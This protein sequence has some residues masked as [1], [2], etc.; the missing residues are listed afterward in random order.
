MTAMSMELVDPDEVGIDRALLEV[1][2]ERVR[3]EVDAGVLPSAQVA[4]ARH[5]RLVA[6]ETYGDATNDYALH[7]AVGRAHDRRRPRCG[8]S[9]ATA[10]STSTSGSATSSPSSRT[11]GKE[12]VTVE[13]VLTHTAGFPFAPLGYPKMLDRADAARGLRPVA[14]RLGARQPGCSST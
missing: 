1:F 5:G 9:S 8:S 14:P 11:N 10:C 2:L 3:L 13:Q 7:P 6:F 12:V 4:V